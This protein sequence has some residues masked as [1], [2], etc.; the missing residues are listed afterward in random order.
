MTPSRLSKGVKTL[1]LMYLEPEGKLYKGES[2]GD[3]CAKW[4]LEIGERCDVRVSMERIINFGTGEFSIFI[5]NIGEIVHNMKELYDV[6]IL[7][8]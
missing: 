4:M 8:I 3:S 6:A 2:C 5:E 7:F 1:I